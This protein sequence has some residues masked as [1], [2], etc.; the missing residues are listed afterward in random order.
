[1]QP[2]DQDFFECI[3]PPWAAAARRHIAETADAVGLDTFAKVLQPVR[4]GAANEHI[5]AKSF[6]AAGIYP[7]NP[8]RVLESGK[9]DPCVVYRSPPPPP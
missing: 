2:L 5:A 8:A 1:M 6:L 7:W 4:V 9:L 3:K